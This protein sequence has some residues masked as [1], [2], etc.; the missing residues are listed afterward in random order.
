MPGSSGALIMMRPAS[1][2]RGV[3]VYIVTSGCMPADERVHGC[4]GGE[5]GEGQAGR[6]TWCALAVCTRSDAC[7]HADLIADPLHPPTPHNT[8]RSQAHSQHSP[9]PPESAVKTR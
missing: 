1:V 2:W 3:G 4:T 9:D 6:S 7:H 5:E 8:A